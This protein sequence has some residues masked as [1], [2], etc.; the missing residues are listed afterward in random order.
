MFVFNISFGIAYAYARS[1][2]HADTIHNKRT[3]KRTENCEVISN[4][5]GDEHIQ[6]DIIEH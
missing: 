1:R 4:R 6:T 5:W 3:T 2:S